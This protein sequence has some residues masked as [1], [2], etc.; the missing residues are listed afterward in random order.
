MRIRSLLAG[1]MTRSHHGGARLATAAM[2]MA[3]VVALLW[4]LLV[5]TGHD[6]GRALTAFWSGSFGSSYTFAS[7]TLVR[8]IP[9]ILAGLAVAIAFRAGVWNIGAEGQLL[10]GAAAAAAV[11]LRL[12]EEMGALS[13]VPATIAGALAGGLLA[14]VAGLLRARFGVIEII[15]TIMLNFVALHIVGYLVRGPLQEPTGLYP[16][17]ATL[18]IDARMPMLIPGTRLHW[19]IVVAVLAAAAIWSVLRFTEIGFRIR[20][21]GANVVAARVAGS[22]DVRATVLT[23]FLA[24]GALAGI[25][26]ALEV[27][28]V[29]Y[30]LYE[31][32]SPGYGYTAIAVAL[33]ARLHPFGILLTG[34]LLGA[35]QAG[36]AAMQ[37]DAG[38]PSV[39]VTIVEA[40][41]ILGMVS[42][43]RPGR[44]HRTAG[45]G[46]GQ[47]ST[48]QSAT[49]A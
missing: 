28:G 33:L 1:E 47:D 17:S 45:D 14:G 40:L 30:A 35:L 6:A 46:I 11:G 42:T 21:V 15:S 25:A 19:G 41:L 24:S 27:S 9:L 12:G 26:G 32:L 39:L 2:A 48:I 29:T 5:I 23:A 20:A 38:V 4:V 22:I 49:T 8:A 31:S 36:G 10:L 16:Q 13:L 3:A 7:A 43:S 37:R 18:P 34:V 44:R